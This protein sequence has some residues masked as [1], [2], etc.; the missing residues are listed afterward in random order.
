MTRAQLISEALPAASSG[1]LG[2]EAK[3]K[4]IEAANPGEGG[5]AFRTAVGTDADEPDGQQRGDQKC[6]GMAP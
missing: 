5:G 6:L 3:K 2:L 4:G 1:S